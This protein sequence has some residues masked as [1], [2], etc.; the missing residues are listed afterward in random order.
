MIFC[1]LYVH[2]NLTTVALLDHIIKTKTKTSKR[3]ESLGS[4]HSTL[5]I[6]RPD[7]FIVRI[8]DNNHAM[9][10]FTKTKVL[11]R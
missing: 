7:V 6:D 3:V 5:I 8:D 10:G 11:E 9:T 1:T 4:K 2:L